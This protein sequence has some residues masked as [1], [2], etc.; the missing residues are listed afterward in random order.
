MRV[1][2][3]RGVRTGAL[4]RR[5]AEKGWVGFLALCLPGAT[6]NKAFVLG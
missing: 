3:G 4:P 2:G 5:L 1:R 6:Q